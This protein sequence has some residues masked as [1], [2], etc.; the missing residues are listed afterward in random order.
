MFIIFVR[1]GGDKK[2]PG[3]Q[4]PRTVL[5]HLGSDQKLLT[6]ARL[7]A[8]WKRNF[9]LLRH[10]LY[11]AKSRLSIGFENFFGKAKSPLLITRASRINAVRCPISAPATLFSTCDTTAT[12]PLCRK[13]TKSTTTNQPKIFALYFSPKFTTKNRTKWIFTNPAPR[14]I[15]KVPSKV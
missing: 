11:H 8:G 10:I 15:M 3:R 1:I 2:T 6:S 9:S 5:R 7:A 14:C 4:A 13:S 12:R